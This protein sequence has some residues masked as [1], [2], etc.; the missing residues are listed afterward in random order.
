MLK[1]AKCIKLIK[2]LGTASNGYTST[3]GT[4]WH[5]AVFKSE[6]LSVSYVGMT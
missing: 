3:E 2:Y 4:K 5:E 6:P 1:D